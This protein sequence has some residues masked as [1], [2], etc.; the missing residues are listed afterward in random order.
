MDNSK[1]TSELMEKAKGKT[2]EE[3]I[4][5]AREEG[6][7]LTDEQLDAISGGSLAGWFPDDV[8]PKLIWKN[9]LLGMTH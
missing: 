4:A 1:I 9:M 2:A 3:L 8:D 5:L 6:I 7:E